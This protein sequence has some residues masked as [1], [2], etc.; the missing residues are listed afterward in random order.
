MLNIK[1]ALTELSE[2]LNALT[3]EDFTNKVTYSEN[4]YNKTF[5]RYGNV[6]AFH[7]QGD[8]IARPESTVL[9]T[10]PDGYR[11]HAFLYFVGIVGGEVETIVQ[12]KPDGRCIIYLASS[13]PKARL[14][15]NGT[16]IL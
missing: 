9:F 12:L 13:Y 2:K 16:F 3:T 14:Y 8:S 15:L 1:K 10:L 4:F 6:I 7:I 5:Y 11:P